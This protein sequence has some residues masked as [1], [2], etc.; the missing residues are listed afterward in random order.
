MEEVIDALQSGQI[1]R[2]ALLEVLS[3]RVH[4]LF[5]INHNVFAFLK[6]LLGQLDLVDMSAD[7]L[8]FTFESRLA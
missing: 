8:I 1:V 5:C 3:E 4:I 7:F 2:L 6:L